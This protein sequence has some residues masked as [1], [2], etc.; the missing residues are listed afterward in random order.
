MLALHLE[1]FRGFRCPWDDPRILF[2][3][4]APLRCPTLQP[5]ALFVL[6][7]GFLAGSFSCLSHFSSNFH[8]EDPLVFKSQLKYPSPRSR[9]PR[10]KR[11]TIIS[12][13]TSWALSPALE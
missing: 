9:Y 11:R 10:E 4:L 7:S 6:A 2:S 8:R 12:L 1:L 13:S 5:Q 3:K